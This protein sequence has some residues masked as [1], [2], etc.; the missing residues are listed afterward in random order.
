MDDDADAKMILTAPPLENWKRP[1][2]HPHITRLNTIQRDVRAYNLTLNA[3]VDLAQ[4]RPLWRLMSMYGALRTPSGACQKRRR[5]L[6]SCIESSPTD[7][8][9]ITTVFTQQA[10]EK[11]D[12]NTNNKISKQ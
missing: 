10:A 3:A 7:S 1:P 4:N 12:T 11:N 2:G 5:L 6:M 8:K 9:T